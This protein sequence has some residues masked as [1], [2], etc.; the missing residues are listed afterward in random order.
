MQNKCTQLNGNCEYNTQ[1]TELESNIQN[2]NI[3][4]RSV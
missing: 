1:R 2:K 3:T 4:D